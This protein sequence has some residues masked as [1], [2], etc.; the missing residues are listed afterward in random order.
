MNEKGK[1]SKEKI[2]VIIRVRGLNDREKNEN[3]EN[4]V[5][6]SEDQKKIYIKEKEYQYNYIADSTISQQNIFDHMGQPIINNVFQG[7]NSSVFAYGQTGSGKT[8]TM[9]G[10]KDQKNKGLIPRIFDSLFKQIEQ[11]SE[12]LNNSG[13]HN[14]QVENKEN[15]QNFQ[16][17]LKLSYFEIYN[18]QI[19]DL[20]NEKDKRTQLNI[21]ENCQNG[22]YIEG[23]T[24]N[25]IFTAKDAI[26]NINIGTKKR[27]V[28]ATQMNFESSR[29]HSI[30]QLEV[31]IKEKSQNGQL[32]QKFS[33]LNFIDLAGSERQKATNASGERLKEANNIN[34]SLTVLGQVIV[35]L[36]DTKQ[37]FIPFRD[38]KLTFALKDSLAGNSRT[39]MIGTISSAS[40]QIAET[41]STLQFAS[42]VKMISVVVNQNQNQGSFIENGQNKLVIQNLESEIK[43][44]KE[45]V[46]Q[47]QL[48][49]EKYNNNQQII[50][51]QEQK[52]EKQ[53]VKNQINKRRKKSE[54]KQKYEQN[55]LDISEDIEIIIDDETSYENSSNENLQKQDILSQKQVKMEQKSV[56]LEQNYIIKNEKENE[57]NE[58]LQN[59]DIDLEIQDTYDNFSDDSFSFDI[60]KNQQKKSELQ[61][62]HSEIKQ[63]LQELALELN[64]EDK[65]QEIDLEE[66]ENEMQKQDEIY[67]QNFDPQMSRYNQKIYSIKHEQDSMYQLCQQPFYQQNYNISKIER[68]YQQEIYIQQQSY[69]DLEKKLM[70]IKEQANQQQFY[71]QEE[72]QIAKNTYYQ[73]VYEIKQK[74]KQEISASEEKIDQLNNLIER[75]KKENELEFLKQQ[76]N[77]NKALQALNSKNQDLKKQLQ[78]LEIQKQKMNGNMKSQIDNGKNIQKSKQIEQNLQKQKPLYQQFQPA[79][80]NK[81]ELQKQEE[82]QKQEKNE[83]QNQ[84]KNEI[85]KQ[86]QEKY[87]DQTKEV[88]EQQKSSK[89]QE[90]QQSVDSQQ[91]QNPQ[92]LQMKKILDIKN[93]IN[94]KRSSYKSS[95]QKQSGENYKNNHSN[96][97]SHPDKENQQKNFKS[98]KNGHKSDTYNMNQ[99]Y[100]NKNMIGKQQQQIQPQLELKRK[101]NNNIN[102]ILPGFKQQSNDNLDQSKIQNQYNN[103]INSIISTDKHKKNSNINQ[104]DKSVHVQKEYQKKM[105]NQNNQYQNKR[106]MNQR[107]S[108]WEKNIQKKIKV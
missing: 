6:I 30:L 99:S 26:K 68:Q 102:K 69:A 98:G 5:S 103:Q 78:A 4:I 55:M 57:M 92:Y 24:K 49:I 84:S 2:N 90:Q 87:K 74:F 39:Y 71:W 18:E 64:Q 83:D 23:I 32:V 52:Q 70:L 1:Y 19:F 35:A 41:L 51:V 46:Q 20:L 16:G 94:I 40:S 63:I 89:I 37:K 80:M 36:G 95:C 45:Q 12:R 44:L 28:G 93:T 107:Y 97:S 65:D 22:V 38:S 15:M 61:E 67:L 47:Q 56:K 91:Y 106:Q 9:F 59:S 54:D 76:Q 79:G 13:I 88:F 14:N 62:Q 100:Q 73:Q 81:Q 48:E 11:Q 7:I 72:I 96:I 43:A 77:H 58:Q 60:Q 86:I 75:I 29:S 108:Q 66:Y 33:K 85:N 34:K 31:Q 21:R 25:P 53:I 10:K 50:E 42:R 105:S 8:Y 17:N 104:I 101:D 27:S 82:K 3:S